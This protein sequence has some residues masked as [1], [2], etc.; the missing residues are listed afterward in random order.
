MPTNEELLEF[1]RAMK[2]CRE[3]MDVACNMARKILTAQGYYWFGNDERGVS[4][5]VL[6]SEDVL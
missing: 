5:W 3:C 1:A 4:V 2:P 6:R